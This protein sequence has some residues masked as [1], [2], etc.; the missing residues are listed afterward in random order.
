[1]TRDQ[2]YLSKVGQDVKPPYPSPYHILSP[3]V[4]DRF[5]P[6]GFASSRIR[7]T[8]RPTGSTWSSWA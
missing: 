4:I 5:W 8:T 6:T 2:L 7:P 3:D 1:V